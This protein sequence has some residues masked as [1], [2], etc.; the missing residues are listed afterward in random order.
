MTSSDP[1]NYDLARKTPGGYDPDLDK[2]GIPHASTEGICN[3]YEFCTGF[4]VSDESQATGE[5]DNRM[6][7]AKLTENGFVKASFLAGCVRD[8]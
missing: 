2:Y 7:K 8:I 1:Y 5:G 3:W 4:R 6:S